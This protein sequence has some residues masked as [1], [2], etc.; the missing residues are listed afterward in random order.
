M[1][2]PETTPSLQKAA[3]DLEDTSRILKE[4]HALIIKKRT[5]LISAFLKFLENDG[6]HIPHQVISPGGRICEFSVL[7]P[8]RIPL[9]SGEKLLTTL[10]ESVRA[11][12]SESEFRMNIEMTGQMSSPNRA[13]NFRLQINQH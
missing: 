8:D 11:Q 5:E 9:L 6:F 12:I 1:G 4:V 2:S 13:V 10:Q 3:S 7:I